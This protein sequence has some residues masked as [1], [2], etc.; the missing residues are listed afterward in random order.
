MAEREAAIGLAK[1][2]L[3][4][5]I[6]SSVRVEGLN[7]TFPQTQEIIRNAELAG[8]TANDVLF[9]VNMRDA[10]RFVLD[11]LDEALNIM[12]VRQLNGICG[13]SLIYGCGAIRTSDVY[14]AG[15]TYKPPI[16]QHSDVV[17]TLSH[18]MREK[19]SLRRV[20]S[21]FAYLAKAQL[22]IDGNKR[23]AQLAANQILVSSGIG[24]LKIPDTSVRTFS[25]CLVDYY[26]TGGNSL[27]CYLEEECLIRAQT[28]ETVSYRGINFTV[29]EIVAALPKALRDTYTSDKQCAEANVG[30]YYEILCKQ[31]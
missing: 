5:C 28:I 10:W 27:T 16:P 24:I 3:V 20:I 25:E 31:G 29:D 17:N 9:V 11:T 18:L 13:H 14:I 30:M 2:Y 6:Y 1:K 26:E 22:F 4:D 23:V 19:D 15:T 7:V 21:T 8:V 12:Y